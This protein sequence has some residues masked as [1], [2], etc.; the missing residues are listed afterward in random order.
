M[1][2]NVGLFRKSRHFV[3][4][5]DT[6][7]S[8][9]RGIDSKMTRGSLCKVTVKGFVKGREIVPIVD[10]VRIVHDIVNLNPPPSYNMELAKYCISLWTKELERVGFTLVLHCFS[11]YILWFNSPTCRRSQASS[12]M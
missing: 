10:V 4:A 7:N 9:H 3:T 2:D 12:L 8:L 6:Y 5:M 1:L 11:A